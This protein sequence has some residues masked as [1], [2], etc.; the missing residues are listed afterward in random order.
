M[1]TVYRVR[2]VDARP[3]ARAQGAARGPRARDGA[4]GALPPRG[5][6]GGGDRAPEH[7]ADHRLRRA[8]RTSAPYFV[9]EL[10]VGAHAR[11]AAQGRRRAPRAAA[12]ASRWRSRRAS[13]RR[14]RRA[15][16]IAISS[17]R[18][19]SSIGD[20]GQRDVRIVDFGVAKVMGGS[21][22][23]R[24][25]IVFGTPH[26]MCPEQ[27]GGQTVDHRADIYALGIILYEMLTGRVPFEADTYMGVLTKHMFV[28][29]PPP[30]RSCRSSAASSA[31]S[32]RSSCA[33]SR[34]SPR[35]GSSRCRTS[36]RRSPPRASTRVAIALVARAARVRAAP[37]P[38]GIADD[39]ELP[40]DGRNPR[41]PQPV[42]GPR[43]P[44]RARGR[45]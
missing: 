29:P 20:E 18:T 13:R 41:A 37:P 36:R 31:R 27:A 21:R 15:S 28:A 4:R 22:L 35:R 7:R 10:L 5:A 38:R 16:S 33:R 26:Y 24:A 2:H 42:R 9:M 30:R 19:C 32:S 43:A 34:R 40:D 3:R 14:T 44:R 25:G 23:T 8:C 6:S 45:S 1:G 12:R 11:G 17:P 39:L